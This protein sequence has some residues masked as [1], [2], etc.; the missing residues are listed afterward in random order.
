[1]GV[2]CLKS[3]HGLLLYPKF[4]SNSV[5][6]NKSRNT[7]YILKQHKKMEMRNFINI[8]ITKNIVSQKSPL[9]STLFLKSSN[10]DP[11]W[12]SW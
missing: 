7:D 8:L 2:R 1:M 4:K 12:L 5:H 10:G 3:L 9:F 6:C 11:R